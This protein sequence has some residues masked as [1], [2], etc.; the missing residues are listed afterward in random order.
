MNAITRLIAISIVLCLIMPPKPGAAQGTA[1]DYARSK[2][3]YEST[4][5][6]V[7][8]W[9]VDPNWLEG[10][11]QFWYRND[12]PDQQREFILVETEQGRRVPAF[13]H[14]KLAA[15][16][17]VALGKEIQG[18]K[19][20]FDS[21]TFLDVTNAIAFTVDGKTWKYVSATDELSEV[22]A[23]KPAQNGDSR[24]RE[25]NERDRPPRQSSPRGDESPDRKRQAFIRDNNLFLRVNETKEEIA[26]SSDGTAEDAYES[27]VYWSPDSQY[28]VA[29]KTRKAQTHPVYLI[30]SSP[31]DQL[32]PRLHQYDYLKPG[33]QI[34][35]SQPRLFS[36]ATRKPVQVSNSL[37][38][39]PW[40]LDDLRWAADSSE[41]TFAYNQRGHQVL[42]IVG[43][44]AETGDVRLVVN[45][46]SPTFIDYAHK[47][48]AR[49]LD[50]TH[51][52]I[53]MSERDG[54]NHLYLYDTAK[55]EVKQQI[56]KGNWTVR[57]VDQV[58][59][60]Q[61]KIWF[62]ASSVFPDQDP[63]YVHYGV[64]SF[65][66]QGLTW[67]TQ[68]DGTHQVEF[69]PDRNF[70]LDSYSRVDLP[71]VT[72]LR[73]V[74]DGS[75]VCELE[76]ADW[77]SLLSTGWKAPERFV[78]K[79]RDGTTDIYGVIY[80]PTHFDPTKTGKYP[81]IEQ[82][83]AGPHGSFVPK[84]FSSYHPPQAM[85]E[86]G[87]IVVQIDGMGTSN[88]SKAFQDV[89]YK[90]I[91]DSGFPDRILWLKAAAAKYPEIDLSRVGIYGGS[92]GGQSS[93][94]ALL[95]HG[96]FYHAAVSDCGCHDNRMDKIW[97]NELWMGHEIGPHYSEQSNVTQA[98]RLQGKL[99][100]VVGEL[101]RNVD[102]ASTM[103]VANALI[104]ADKDFDLLIIPG[105]GHG[106]CESP[107]GQRRRQDFFVRHLLGVEPRR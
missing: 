98:H 85:A 92:A 49:Y 18:T 76:R 68:G 48:F 6:K 100:L 65:D 12:L 16:L 44:K 55:G 87:F 51:E 86:L 27:G 42:R 4:R 73:R 3:L 33:D 36:I 29:I 1:A 102:P 106:A 67:L 8:R 24:R 30:E 9:R 37:F 34:A 66:G 62:R 69:S 40:S 52:M 61:R 45:E 96:D 7:F 105:A 35:Q 75:L 90:N 107:Y 99:M 89:A 56:T 104:K 72:E 31:G 25:R 21:I 38:A 43:V 71:P 59:V 39:N 26:L 70:I 78:A 91:G 32:Q 47:Q 60:E 58:D 5:N 23:I 103:Q 41:F 81:V 63:Y 77:S 64:I 83:Y 101:D 94:R 46:E 28:C 15:R 95:A 2:G 80:R 17:S 88:R 50:Q 11:R 22:E 82:I 97:W 79:G 20:P 74:S 53:W 54:W 13:D 57:R 19:L 93:T 10:Q 84:Q 14:S